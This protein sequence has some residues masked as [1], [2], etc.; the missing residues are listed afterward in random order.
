M[1]EEEK[2]KNKYSPYIVIAVKEIDSEISL[3]YAHRQA[4]SYSLATTIASAFF[5]GLA[6][7]AR[8]LNGILAKLHVIQHYCEIF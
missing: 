8:C 6:Q 3:A 1:T 4:F 5:K 2:C 7:M